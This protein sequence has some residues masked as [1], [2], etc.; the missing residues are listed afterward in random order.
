MN[1]FKK[2]GLTALAGS[3]AISAAHAGELSVSGSMVA[4]Y[5]KLDTKESTANP[6][7]MK[8]NLTFSGSSELDNGMTAS[9]FHTSSDKFAGQ[10][11]GK[12]TLDMNE[13]G[14]IALDQ[15][16]GGGMQDID[17]V[18]PKAYEE[19][20]DN[21]DAGYKAGKA[22]TN[23]SG[24]LVYTNSFS[25][26]DVNVLFR[27]G[28]SATNSDGSTGGDGGAHQAVTLQSSSLGV[29]GLKVGIG[30][31]K[32]DGYADGDD[33]ESTAYVTYASPTGLSLGYQIYDY[34]DSASANSDE[35]S[36]MYSVAY[37]VNDDLSI[38]YGVKSVDF[39]ASGKGDTM[40]TTGLGAAY[41][42]G[43][44]TLSIQKNE[45]EC[46]GGTCTTAV[47]DENLEVAVSFAF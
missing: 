14:T 32:E 38:S 12:I 15:G 35:D 43:G 17:D 45:G 10:Y 24:G 42:S 23:A 44:I 28:G 9:I 39:S 26:V 21:L 27:K 2:V 6:M 7:G 3:L 47:E 40:K 4:T 11:S 29:D 41:S 1:N 20:W 13:A 46:A 5:N 22:D 8:S 34:D 37:S 31:S 19:S 25:G 16:S 30:F 18:T 33:E 36:N